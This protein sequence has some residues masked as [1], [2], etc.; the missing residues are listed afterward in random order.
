MNLS[1][2]DVEVDGDRAVAACRLRQEFEL[3][4]G[5]ATP[6]D[7]AVRFRLRRSASGWHIDAVEN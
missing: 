5:R 3:K 7:A 2:C 1:D 6:R 4:V